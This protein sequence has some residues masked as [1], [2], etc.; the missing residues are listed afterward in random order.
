[1]AVN[2]TGPQWQAMATVKVVDSGGFPVAGATVT[3]SWS[4]LVNDGNTVF[5][6]NTDGVAGPFYSTRTKK[7]GTITFTVTSVTKDGWTYDAAGSQT[8]ASII[9]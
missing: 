6:T 8:S 7:S 9:R 4:G 1:M 5:A 2:V 3:G